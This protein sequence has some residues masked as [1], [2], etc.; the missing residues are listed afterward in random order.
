MSQ[1]LSQRFLTDNLKL[2][3]TN[4]LCRSDLGPSLASFLLQALAG[5]ANPLLLVRVGGAQRTKVRSHLAN[6]RF[7]RAADDNVGLLVDR[8]VDS[9]GNRKLH[10]VGLAESKRHG[11]SL[12]FRAVADA[13]NVEFL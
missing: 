5:N 8:D 10:R 4:S 13:D 2:S 7:I 11:F 12:H 3:T 1:V 6:L 9:L